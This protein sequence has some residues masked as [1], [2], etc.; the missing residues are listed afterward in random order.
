MSEFDVI[1]KSTPQLSAMQKAM[2]RTQYVSDLVLPYMLHGAI[3]KSPHA[4]ARI[5]KL[6]TS[7]AKRL[8][9]VR[10]VITYADT[11]GIKY[12][13]RSEDW[14][15]FAK[16]RVLFHGHEVAAVA[17]VDPETAAE[18]LR[19]I[20][21]EYEPLPWV[22]DPRKALEEDAPLVIEEKGDNLAF[23]FKI[24]SGEVDRALDE[25]YYVYEDHYYTNQVYQAYLETMGCVAE[26]DLNGRYVL[27]AG[28]QIPNMMRM[29]YAKALGV[30]PDRVQVKVPEYGGAFGGKME[31]N[32]H[33][34]TA[35]LAEKSGRPVR[36]FYNRHEDFI[37]GNPRVPMHFDIKLGV[38]KHGHI[39]AKDVKV[40]GA[41]GARLVYGHIILM[42]ACY[43]VDS[44][45][46]FP[47]VRAL[48]LTAY[49]H[50][51]PT[52]CYRGF[53]NSQATFVLESS[54]DMVAERLGMD[55]AELR[56]IN[57]LGP[58]STSIHG[59]KINSN[60]LADCVKLA[61]DKAQWQSKRQTSK[62]LRGIGLACCNHV[63]GNR[64]F[65]REFDGAAG[66]VHVGR[67]GR[68]TVFHGESDM[69]Q[70][71]HTVFAQ[72]VA[73]RLGVPLNWVNV[74]M[75]DTDIS[76][77]GCGSFATRGTLM[78]G[79]GVLA[80]AKDA[81]D[82][83]AKTAARLLEANIAD[84]RCRKG[85][86]FPEGSPD[87]TVDWHTVADEASISRKGAP[88]MGQGFYDPP[89][90]LPDPKTKYGNISPAYPF[91]CQIAEVEVDP[92]TGQVTVVSFVAAHDVGRALNPIALE[93]QIQ[94]GVAQ[95]M[96]WALTEDMAYDDNGRLLNPDFV[97][98]VVP[99]PQDVPEIQPILVEPVEKEGPYGAKGIGEP[100]LNPAMAAIT[101]AIY[102]AT[103][104]RI[105]RLPASPEFI[106]GELK[107]SK[108]DNKIIY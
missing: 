91:A 46:K 49:T 104:I 73:E 93:G 11:P 84:I 70:G 7:K 45:Y 21:V 102:N 98:Y 48:G 3:L 99:G 92:D 23:E 43:R 41:A 60:A 67:D 106:L 81:F 31:H 95:G 40:V 90:V 44:L 57:D 25:S 14:Y 62:P 61:S 37:A 30:S 18:A 12:G 24:E 4:H 32:I 65:A 13:P 89:T 42:T 101:N 17:A 34:I 83:L 50:S 53:G 29:T 9:G 28:T 38:D 47:N 77:F 78:G 52:S 76:P 86:F 36:L 108:I 16:D 64:P 68:I 71:Q 58:D 27:Y 103:G 20:E 56:L 26:M 87:R 54:L 1:G 6:D 85:K 2:G 72:I 35:L 63:S 82:Q 97:D 10:A 100:A 59:W 94:G 5:L 66:I 75:V 69:G 55:P 39:T 19:L 33:L 15:I 88:V 79:N 80:A 96:G 74:A 22:I 8:P 107:K 105:K 51:V